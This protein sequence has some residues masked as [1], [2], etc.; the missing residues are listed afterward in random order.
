MACHQLRGRVGRGFDDSHCF[1]LVEGEDETVLERLALF[2]R[3]SDGFKLAEADLLSRG[4]GQIFGERQS[5]LGDLQVAS[6]VRDRALLEEAR[7]EAVLILKRAG[8]GET[9]ASLG[10]VFDA[11]EA[12]FGGRIRWMDRV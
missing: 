10:Y 12:R 11:A 6:L 7:A 2:A 3:T 5:G 4:E 9:P 1:L 8:A